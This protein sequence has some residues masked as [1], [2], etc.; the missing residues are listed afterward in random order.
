[1]L[2]AG[3]IPYLNSAPFFDG[4]PLGS[5]WEL[6]DLVPRVLGAEAAAGGVSAGLLPIADFFRLQGTFERLGRFGIAVRGKARSVTL[7]SR[8]PIRQ[9]DGCAIA[10][11]EE[12]STSALLLRLLLEQRYHVRPAS[13]ERGPATPG[14]D[15]LLLIG[16]EALRFQQANARYPFEIDVAFEWWLWQHAPFVFAVWAIR[17]DADL[18]EKSRL[19]RALGKAL[20]MNT[21]RLAQ[22]AQERSSALGVPAA[23][24]ESYLSSFIYRLGPSE[25]AAIKRFEALVHEHHLL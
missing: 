17:K 25:G 16:D 8:K 6:T 12:S 19:E 22:L 23:D 24:L 10:V 18:E 20:A 11:T 21:G 3:R 13:F 2:R 7:F 1:M 15:A 5:R 9:L 14:A 4:L